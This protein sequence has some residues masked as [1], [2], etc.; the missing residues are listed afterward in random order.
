MSPCAVWNSER[1]AR[2]PS[3]ATLCIWTEITMLDRYDSVTVLWNNFRSQLAIR[4]TKAKQNSHVTFYSQNA[5]AKY[6]KIKSK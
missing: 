4:I 2:P 1:R 5:M 3:L 6:C